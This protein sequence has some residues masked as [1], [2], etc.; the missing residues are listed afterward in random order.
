M[1]CRPNCHQRC[2]QEC[3]DRE[4]E[5]WRPSPVSR[6]STRG[7]RI[8][9]R[10][11]SQPTQPVLP[12]GLPKEILSRP[13]VMYRMLTHKKTTSSPVRQIE[14][15]KSD[16][17]KVSGAKRPYTAPVPR[18][19]KKS[20]ASAIKKKA[21]IIGSEEGEPLSPWRASPDMAGHTRSTTR[22]SNRSSQGF[23]ASFA[24]STPEPA[25]SKS[26][27]TSTTTTSARFKSPSVMQDRKRKHGRHDACGVHDEREPVLSE[28]VH[29][30]GSECDGAGKEALVLRCVGGD[31]HTELHA[32]LTCLGRCQ[33]GAEYS[34]AQAS[35]PCREDC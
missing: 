35:Y 22:A 28:E 17:G 15:K 26:R 11:N 9:S 6:P 1:F 2:K 27:P 20:N 3:H 32:R 5:W 4:K 14:P 18:D 25:T 24:D 7:S 34:T 33:T 29:E 16:N 21:S 12:E 30:M 19:S 10:C 31:S 8:T 23:H 13:D